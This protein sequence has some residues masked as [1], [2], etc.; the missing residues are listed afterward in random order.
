MDKE[1]EKSLRQV[2]QFGY[3]FYGKSAFE[4]N[5]KMIS[6]EC[7]GKKIGQVFGVMLD[8][9]KQIEEWENELELE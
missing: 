2:A 7:P 5:V 1:L 9:I 3:Y 4:E 6:K 8:E